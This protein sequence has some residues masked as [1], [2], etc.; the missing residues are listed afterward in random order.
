VWVDRAG[1]RRSMLDLLATDRCTLIV[2]RDGAAWLN[3]ADPGAIRMLVPG[4]D[5]A[6]IDGGW[7][8]AAEIG[9]DGALL[10]RPDQHVAWRTM[11]ALDDPAGALD[12][13]LRHVSGR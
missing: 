10:V 13:V 11:G 3:A 1:E 9:A 8:R 7:A 2:G 6:D 12:A 4:R 5:F